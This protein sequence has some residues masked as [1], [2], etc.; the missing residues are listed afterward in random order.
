MRTK[1]ARKPGLAAVLLALGLLAAGDAPWPRMRPDYR[2][3]IGDQFQ[4][5]VLQQADLDRVL[6]VRPDG[7][8]IVP[9][10]GAVPVAGLTIRDAEESD[11]PETAP[12]QPRHQRRL[13][14]RHAVQ[15]LADRGARRRHQR[16]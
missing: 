3:G 12:V 6:A 14:H 4:L 1:R 11:P 15:R 16:G 8:V 5:S 10:V 13:A 2:L 7:S 9:L